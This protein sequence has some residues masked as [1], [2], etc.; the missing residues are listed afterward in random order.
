[1]T[2]LP[3]HGLSQEFPE[4]REQIHSLNL[5]DATFARLLAEYHAKDDEVRRI[6]AGIETAASIYLEEC[7]KERLDLK[8]QL[9]S[10]LLEDASL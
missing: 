4:F 10:L 5:S 7:K 2:D 3:K 1:M 9:Y 6:E 8:E